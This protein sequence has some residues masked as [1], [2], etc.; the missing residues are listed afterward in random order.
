MASSSIDGEVV[1]VAL[2]HKHAVITTDGAHFLHMVL[3]PGDVDCGDYM[4]FVSGRRVS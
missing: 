3:R 4:L 1:A 2:G